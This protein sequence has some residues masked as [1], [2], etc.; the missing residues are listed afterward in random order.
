[1]VAVCRNII[2]G[3]VY[4]GMVI[5]ALDKPAVIA[6]LKASVTRR[7][8]SPSDLINPQLELAH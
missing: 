8:R 2:T 7:N 5:V 6:L 3:P 4:G 1:M